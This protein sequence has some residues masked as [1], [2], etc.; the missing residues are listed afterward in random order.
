[1]KVFQIGFNKC[2]TK[3]LRDWFIQ[4][5]YNSVHW[6]NYKW[7]NHFTKNQSNDLPLCDGAD[8]VVFWSD[9][10]F[11]QRQFQIFAEQYPTSKFIYNIR[12]VDEW[13]DS[14]DRQYKKHPQAFTD[15]FGFTIDNQLDRMDYWK[16]EWFYHKKVI[17]EYFVGKKSKRLLTF[18]I[19]EDSP[20]KIVDFLTELDFGDMNFPWR[21]KG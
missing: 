13:L 14:R 10:G 1:M 5:G 12:N 20:Q 8:D 4:N 18:N 9:I 6:D 21:N 19:G 7:D 2:G 3:S 16:S 17:D 11:V 15:N